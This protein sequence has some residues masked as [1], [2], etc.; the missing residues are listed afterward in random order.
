MSG[1]TDPKDLL[2]AMNPVLHQEEFV[3]CTV[4]PERAGELDLEPVCLFRENEGVAM[5]MERHLADH[6][7]LQYEF[8]CKMITLTVHSSLDAVGFLAAI[9]AKLTEYGISVNPVSAF[10]HDYLFV[11]SDKAPE[12]MNILAQLYQ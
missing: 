4:T 3:F 5:I 12:A 11:R 6:N 10:Y 8:V 1:K 9:T 7:N 2:K